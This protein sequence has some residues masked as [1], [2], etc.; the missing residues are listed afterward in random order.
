[1]FGLIY[2]LSTGFTTRLALVSGSGY[3]LSVLLLLASALIITRLA[4]FK[5]EGRDTRNRIPLEQVGIHSAWF[6]FEDKE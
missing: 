1:M 3:L 6:W 2:I 4:V 5:G